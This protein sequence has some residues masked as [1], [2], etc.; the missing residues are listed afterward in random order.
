MMPYSHRLDVLPGYGC[1]GSQTGLS[2][3]V[4]FTAT[5]HDALTAITAAVIPLC[6]LIRRIWRMS[7]YMEPRRRSRRKSKRGRGNTRN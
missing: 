2:V 7:A 5:G 4:S 3:S 6:F 1:E